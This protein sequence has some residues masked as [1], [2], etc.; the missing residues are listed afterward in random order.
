M[1]L[2][3]ADILLPVD[4]FKPCGISAY[5][6]FALIQWFVHFFRVKSRMVRVGE[7]AGRL[8][9]LFSLDRESFFYFTILYFTAIFLSFSIFFQYFPE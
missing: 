3:H 7:R 8:A 1:N 4:Y 6:R 9:F 2:V 5:E